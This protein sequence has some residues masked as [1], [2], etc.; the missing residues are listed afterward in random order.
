MLISCWQCINNCNTNY[1]RHVISITSNDKTIIIIIII[2]IILKWIYDVF[3]TF[4]SKILIQ[5]EKNNNKIV[6]SRGQTSST[7]EPCIYGW[8][9]FVPWAK[10]KSSQVIK[11]NHFI[12][13]LNY[14]LTLPL[15]INFTIENISIATVSICEGR[16]FI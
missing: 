4:I 10:I 11:S 15:P 13:Y 2:I 14:P 7:L 1:K 12:I 9:C 6:V 8:M 5:I 16:D 3:N